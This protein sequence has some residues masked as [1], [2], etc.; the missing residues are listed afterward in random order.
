MEKVQQLQ[1]T[2]NGEDLFPGSDLLL[3]VDHLPNMTA[4][5][6]FA[7]RIEAEV[8]EGRGGGGVAEESLLLF[9]VSCQLGVEK[10][11]CLWVVCSVVLSEREAALSE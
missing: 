1:H 5:T 10:F 3:V 4:C 2:C 8:G 6:I 11:V 9:S 7:A